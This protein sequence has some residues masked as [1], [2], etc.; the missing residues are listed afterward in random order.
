MD[1]STISHLPILIE[2]GGDNVR[3]WK[4]LFHTVGKI[5]YPELRLDSVL[6]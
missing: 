3:P 4:I 5:S 6:I 2:G 1:T